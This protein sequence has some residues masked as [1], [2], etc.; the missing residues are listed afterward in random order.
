ML[1]NIDSILD[2]AYTKLLFWFFSIKILFLRA[3]FGI[4]VAH[5]E[6][7]LKTMRQYCKSLI[8]KVARGENNVFMGSYT[9]WKNKGMWKGFCNKL[10]LRCQK[11]GLWLSIRNCKAKIA[12]Q[13]R[14][15]SAEVD[16]WRAKHE[17][18][19]S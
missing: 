8:S 16:K 17:G 13:Q 11:P 18:E 15:M 4:K 3:P 9:G 6:T 1:V 7:L 2:V 14:E 12:I 5:W 10:G 19:R